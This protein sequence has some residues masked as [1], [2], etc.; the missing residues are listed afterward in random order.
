M[1]YNMTKTSLFMYDI[2][3]ELNH[4]SWIYWAKRPYAFWNN[5]TPK[6]PLCNHF[7]QPTKASIR[8]LSKAFI[9]MFATFDDLT[10]RCT[11]FVRARITYR[12]TQTVAG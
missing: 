10:M 11:Y 2:L 9:S 4:I 5:T 3:M 7:K 1:V 12:V 6:R 8:A